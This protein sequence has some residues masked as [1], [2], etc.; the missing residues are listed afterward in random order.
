MIF[1]I[2][3]RND[4]PKKKRKYLKIKKKTYIGKEK[5]LS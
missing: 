1:K 5:T 2:T 3:D 4:F